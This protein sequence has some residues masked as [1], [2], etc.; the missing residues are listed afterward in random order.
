MAFKQ[1]GFFPTPYGMA[2]KHHFTK[3]S[4][5]LRRVTNPSSLSFALTNLVRVFVGK[6]IKWSELVLRYSVFQLNLSTTIMGDEYF[7]INTRKKEIK[8]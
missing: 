2:Q 4:T 3:S 6:I 1:Y 7:I 8:L 5:K